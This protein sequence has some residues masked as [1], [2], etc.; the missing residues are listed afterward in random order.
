[1]ANS[2]TFTNLTSNNFD[3]ARNALDINGLNAIRQQSKSTD[4][5]SKKAALTEAAQQF[6]AIFMKMLLK[7]MRKAQE[8]LESDSP[9]N[10]QSTK[11]YRDMHDEQMAIELSSNGTLGLSDLI[12]RQ[13]GGDDSFTPSSVLRSDGS[14]ASARKF[15]KPQESNISSEEG[16]VDIPFA[17][18]QSVNISTPIFE[19]PKDFVSALTE[20]AKMVQEKLGVPFQVVIAQAALETG[21]GQKIIQADDGSSSNNLFNIKADNRWAGS[22]I[23]KDTLE[24]EQGTMVKKSA[25]FRAYQSL[26]ESVDDYVNFL[27]DNDRYQGALQNASDVEHFLHGLQQAGY[28]TDPQ[29]ANKI[30]ATL[31]TVTNL[32]TQ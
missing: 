2:D 12:V 14:L 19:Q 15:A 8:V 25:P 1:M 11:F 22:K 3:Q 16:E 6:E 18:K 9:F 17:A 5:E 20:P 32:I 29:Y 21:W 30:M 4:G 31:R 26:S 28:A 7:S 10:S 24:F 27:S 23:Q 13:L